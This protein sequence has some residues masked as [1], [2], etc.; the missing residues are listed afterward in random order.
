M[1]QAAEILRADLAYLE[2]TADQLLQKAANGDRLNR[3]SLQPAPLAIQ[4]RAIR[5]FLPRVMSR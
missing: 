5:Q 4:R 3:L 2:N 1:A